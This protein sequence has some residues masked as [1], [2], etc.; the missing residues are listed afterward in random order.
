M[1]TIHVVITKEFTFRGK[2]ERFSNGYNL[3]IGSND[4][5]EAYVKSVA[6]ALVAMERAF[7]T[8]EIKFPY[9]VGGLLGQP[10]VYAEEVASPPTGSFTA[11]GHSHPEECFMAESRIGPKRYLR[12]YYHTGRGSNA[13]GLLDT[14]DGTAKSTAETQLLKLTNGTLPGAA[15]YCRPNG[16]LATN[17]FTLDPFVRTHQLKRR[18]KRP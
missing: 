17:P 6:D 4:P 13:S 9:R 7:H 3:Q 15:T 12:K 10:A 8:G 14:I 1:P 11:I 16:A 18:G 5:T 2:P